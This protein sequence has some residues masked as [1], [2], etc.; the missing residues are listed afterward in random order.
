MPQEETKP[1]RAWLALALCLCA[2]VASAQAL[3]D[4]RVAGRR[5]SVKCGVV[6]RALDPAH[7]DGAKIGVHYVVVPAMARRKLADPV[8]LLAG[9]PG[10][11]A[12]DIAPQVM[13]LFARLNNRRD[14]VFVDQRGT[15]AA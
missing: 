13:P 10:Q 8:F 12:I 2:G 4:C 6:L 11:S 3:T 14:I 1:L 9:G 7:P 15:L 5:N